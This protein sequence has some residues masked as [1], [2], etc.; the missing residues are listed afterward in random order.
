MSLLRRANPPDERGVRFLA[1][2]APKEWQA[3]VMLCTT[4]DSLVEI[5]PRLGMGVQP[6]K[7]CAHRLYALADVENRIG[8]VNFAFRHR[9]LLCPCCERSG[10]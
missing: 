1:S 9:V 2:L 4:A 10:E 5:A 8:L 6:L 3:L 7:N